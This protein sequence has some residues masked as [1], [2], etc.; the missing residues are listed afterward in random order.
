MTSIQ[1]VFFASKSKITDLAELLGPASRNGPENWLK[2]TQNT[3]ANETLEIGAVFFKIFAG[4]VL[5]LTE[6]D[7]QRELIHK[8][9]AVFLCRTK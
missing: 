7:H 5:L 4:I 9:I 8:I 3:P 1:H 6:F 2:L